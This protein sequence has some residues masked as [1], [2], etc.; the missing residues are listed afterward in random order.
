MNT[1]NL[2]PI[3]QWCRNFLLENYGIELLPV[4]C[5]FQR[6]PFHKDHKTTTFRPVLVLFGWFFDAGFKLNQVFK[7]NSQFTLLFLLGGTAFFIKIVKHDVRRSANRRTFLRVK[8]CCTS[9][10]PRLL[11][12]GNL[13]PIFNSQNIW[14]FHF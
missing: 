5:S 1:R 12:R 6:V 8:W 2:T 4:F 10:A 13:D 7:K 11:H 3:L 9:A 14:E